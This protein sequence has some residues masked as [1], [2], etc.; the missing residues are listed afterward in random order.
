MGTVKRIHGFAAHHSVYAMRTNGKATW[1]THTRQSQIRS[2]K[3]QSN[4]VLAKMIRLAIR[5]TTNR[6][7]QTQGQLFIITICIN[8]LCNWQIQNQQVIVLTRKLHSHRSKLHHIPVGKASRNTP[9]MGL[10]FVSSLFNL[11]IV[12]LRMIWQ[13]R[14]N[15]MISYV[16][17]RENLS[18]KRIE[19]RYK[20]S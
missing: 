1:I 5:T 2:P 12:C 3:Y 9:F 20:R 13:N 16:V 4:F 7:Y 14:I 11:L 15:V 10:V 8:V 17:K 6:Q 19:R 18:G